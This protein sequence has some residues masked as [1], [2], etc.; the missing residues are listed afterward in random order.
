M[1]PPDNKYHVKITGFNE[2]WSEPRPQAWITAQSPATHQTM[3]MVEFEI[4]EGKGKGKRFS[5]RVGC[6]VG[7]TSNLGKV[8]LATVGAIPDPVELTD[9]LGHELTIYVVRKDDVDK[10]GNKVAYANPT[11]STAKAL[12]DKSTDDDDAEGWPAA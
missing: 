6:L 2:P 10:N 8:W 7:P 3:T 4:M 5:S 11:W 1:P 9:I 12:G